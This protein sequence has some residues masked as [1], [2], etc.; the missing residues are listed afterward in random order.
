[1][2][3]KLIFVSLIVLCFS[4]TGCQDAK[5]V[6]A[7]T[8][9][10]LAQKAVESFNNSDAAKLLPDQAQEIQ[11]TL[12]AATDAFN[13]GDYTGAVESAKKL[14]GMVK[15]AMDAYTTKKQEWTAKLEDLNKKM[16][17]LTA[18]VQ[19]KI[20]A[21]Q[22]SHKLPAGVANSFAQYKTTWSEA[23]AAFKSGD[24]SVAVAKA[25]AAKDQLASLQ[26]ALHI[27]P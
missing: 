26:A 18:A 12:Q 10:G 24:I 7:K 2:K 3:R 5:K 22:K 21:L 25:S 14:P 17:E 13:K 1:M 16:P 20:D 15:D 6:A 23:S 4:F 19:S 11:N 8:A 9:M 27:N